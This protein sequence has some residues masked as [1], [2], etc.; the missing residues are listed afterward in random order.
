MAV[1]ISSAGMIHRVCTTTCILFSL[2]ALYYMNKLSQQTYNVPA[3]VPP[4]QGK[5]KKQ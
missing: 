2:V 3:V 1:A 5:R 4:P